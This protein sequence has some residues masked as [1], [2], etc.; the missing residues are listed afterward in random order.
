MDDNKLLKKIYILCIILIISFWTVVLVGG[1][2]LHKTLDSIQT[3]QTQIEKAAENIEDIDIES[4]N[5]TIESV[6][7]TLNIL[8]QATNTIKGLF[9]G[10]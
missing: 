5:E 7:D 8:N 1:F 9:E 10:Q 6:N 2:S 3:T 4:V